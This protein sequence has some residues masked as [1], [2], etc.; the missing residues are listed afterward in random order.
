MKKVFKN[1]KRRK[2]EKELQHF[3]EIQILD[4]ESKKSVSSYAECVE[5]G[6]IS[7]FYSEWKISS[8]ALFVTYLNCDG[9][10]KIGKTIKNYLDLFI[11]TSLNQRSIRSRLVSQPNKK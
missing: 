5:S 4:N 8:D 11:N 7:S 10:N 2:T 1:K 6:E 9:E 3:Q